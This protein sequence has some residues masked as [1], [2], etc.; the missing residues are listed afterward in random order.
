[1][2]DNSLASPSPGFAL[3]SDEE[4]ESRTITRAIA[5]VL[6]GAVH[7]L[8]F[9]MFLVS[10]H[11]QT[12]GRRPPLETMLLLPALNGKNAPE[13]HMVRPEVPSEAEP[14]IVT[15]PITIP[16]PPPPPPNQAERPATP[17][18]VLKAVGEALSCGAGSFETLTPAERARC[19]HEPWLA[20][21]APNGALVMQPTLAPRLAEPQPEFHLSGADAQRRALETAPTGC[22]VLLNI[23]CLAKLP[24][25]N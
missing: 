15:A 7:F 22:P 11:Q 12:F 18:D 1:M 21:R 9:L 8:F 14:E 2:I 24:S 4:P 25:N 17:G 3:H 23:P 10:V 16:K 5:W 19:R 13:V 20:R 6:V